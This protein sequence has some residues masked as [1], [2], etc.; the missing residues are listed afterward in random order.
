MN[1]RELMTGGGGGAKERIYGGFLPFLGDS[2]LSTHRMGLLG[3][4]THFLE[5]HS[6]LLPPSS[7]LLPPLLLQLAWHGT[8]PV[9]QTGS[10]TVLSWCIWAHPLEGLD[11][12]TLVHCH[13]TGRALPHRLRPIHLPFSHLFVC[14][15]ATYN[16]R[17]L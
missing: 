10:I 5:R 1:A 12:A 6:W 16:K 4:G 13:H 7:F 14:K 2:T 8:S 15:E 17:K 9:P 3:G 11:M